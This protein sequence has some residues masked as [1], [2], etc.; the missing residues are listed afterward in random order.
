MKI[1]SKAHYGL[2]ASI[3][4][5]TNYPKTIPAS[6][7]EK[8]IGVSKKYL[9]RIMRALSNAGVVCATRGASG[10]YT[11]TR[12][13]KDISCGVVIRALED[14]LKIVDCVV[15]PC[16]KECKSLYVWKKLYDG[17][18]VL[19]DDI[20]LEEASFRNKEN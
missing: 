10:G 6:E 20:S 1:S 11:L 7:L 3:I 18:N 14:D 8:Q 4:L 15:K 12:Q 13:P 9:E 17:I 19:L 5:A 2:Q 16:S